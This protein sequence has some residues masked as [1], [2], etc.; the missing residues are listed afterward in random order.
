M[1][2]ITQNKTNKPYPIRVEFTGVT[3]VGK[4]T[5]I[6]I[7]KQLL[8]EK[9][10]STEEVDEAILRFYALT[11]IRNP[12]YRTLTIHFLVFFPFLQYILSLEGWKLFC[13]AVNTTI[14]TAKNL[15]MAVY[16]I[17]GFFVKI[18][19]NCL[20]E[21]LKKTDNT[22]RFSWDLILIDE[23]TLHIVHTLFV[24]EESQPCFEKILQ[25]SHLVPQPDLAIWITAEPEKS[26]QCT[27][28]RGH[29]R[30]KNDKLYAQ[31]FVTYAY[32]S[33]DHLL[34]SEAIESKIFKFDYSG[35]RHQDPFL[36]Q[37]SALTITDFLQKNLDLTTSNPN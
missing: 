28:Q 26:I 5:L 25:F 20:L 10:I 7:V 36:D 21:R 8:L 17:R 37:R 1:L 2:N 24:H 34:S 33:F 35:D 15:K 13:L 6:P 23:G 16:M 27:L 18:G 32:Q 31:N 29:K 11:F 19:R 12:R 3:G 9:G 22:Q 4:T 14:K 30:V